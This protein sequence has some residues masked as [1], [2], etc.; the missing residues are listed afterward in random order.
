MNL[1]SVLPLL[2][3]MVIV[4]MIGSILFKSPRQDLQSALAEG[5]IWS[6]SFFVFFS[7]EFLLLVR[8]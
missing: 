4:L 8:A 2:I 3:A 7:A 5:A 1:L 6:S